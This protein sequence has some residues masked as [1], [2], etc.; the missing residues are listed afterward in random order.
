MS[1][2]AEGTPI[3]I[4]IGSAYVKVGY[5]GDPEPRFI[6][7]C[8]TGT[9]KYQTVMVDVNA[10]NLYVGDDAMKMRGVL[11]LERPI[12]RGQIQDWNDY[13]EILNHI[14]Y[15]LLRLESVANYP[16]IYIEHPFVANETKE[17]IARVL[18]ETHGVKSLVMVPSPLLSIFS[19]GL[20]TGLVL[21]SGDGVTWI[22][23]IIDGQIMTQ[24]TQRLYLAGMDVNHNFKSLLMREGINLGAS[25]LEQIIQEIKE[26]NCYMVLDPDNPS[27]TRDALQHSMPDGSIVEIP[28]RVLYEAPEVLF[29]PEMLGYNMMNITQATIHSLQMM[30]NTYWGELLS[31]IVLS[32]GNLSYSGFIERFK[33][34]LRKSLPQL[35]S[36]PKPAKS[37]EVSKELQPVQGK[38]KKT[39][40]C[41]KCGELVDLSE[42]KDFCPHCG[43]KM[44]VPEISLD[45]DLGGR[46]E[47]K[48][49]EVPN[50]L[51]CPHC[52]K[53]ITDTT[54]KFCPYC[55]KNIPEEPD[56]ESVEDMVRGAPEA[57]EFSGFYDEAEEII[58][59]YIPNNLQTAIFNGASILG[60]LPSFQQLFITHTEFQKNKN[61]LYRDISEIL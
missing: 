53:E 47:K 30:E 50:E 27:K 52:E 21:E 39:D 49:K 16:V 5:G 29:Q 42:D 43:A 9:E 44:K 40:T 23:P 22:V 45:L 12:E 11:K 15:N 58:N 8:I 24:A 14:F 10:R 57:E 20:T 38:E 28:N 17:Y 48:K 56:L 61:L 26:K 60:S 1:E 31:H 33:Q 54:S 4:D 6:F 25:A 3:I 35:G 32:G 18:F 46:K 41:P 13:Y 55:G 34:E 59:F 19:V 37:R 51:F 36:I 7:P 2:P